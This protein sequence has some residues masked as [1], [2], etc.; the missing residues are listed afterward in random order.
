MSSHQAPPTPSATIPG[1]AQQLL[2]EWMKNFVTLYN[3]N[4]GAMN[5]DPEAYRQA[6][7]DTIVDTL[8][9]FD[10]HLEAVD[11]L[12]H[13]VLRVTEKAWLLLHPRRVPSQIPA[14][15]CPSPYRRIIFLTAL[16]TFWWPRVAS[17]L[18]P[19]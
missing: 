6:V 3:D 8:D 19:T 1:T 16:C 11:P 10:C 14:S 18:I 17:S 7:N 12:Y 15:H 5:V 13:F 2:Y 4:C 9:E